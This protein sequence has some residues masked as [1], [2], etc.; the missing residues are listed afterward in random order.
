M[1]TPA[2]QA[3]PL[4]PFILYSFSVIGV[5]ALLLFVSWISGERHREG[6]TG[7]PYESGIAPAGIPGNPLDIRYYM[8]GLLFVV[9]DIEVVFFIAWALVV[10]EAGWTGFAEM[11]AFTLTLAVALIYVLR[12]GALDWGGRPAGK[13]PERKSP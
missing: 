8:A 3:A 13:L 7:T 2:F 6:A 11:L 10:R 1:Q 5:V 9:F 4:W 12:M